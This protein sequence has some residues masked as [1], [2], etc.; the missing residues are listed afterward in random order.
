MKKIFIFLIAF[1]TSGVT[2]AADTNEVCK[3][4]TLVMVVLQ[5]KTNGKSVDYDKDTMRWTVDFGYDLFASAHPD[6]VV[7]TDIVGRTTCNDINV[8]SS[9]D[10]KSSNAGPAEPGDANTFLKASHGDVG[11]NCWCKMDGPVTSWWTYVKEYTSDSECA[12]YCTEYCAT[13]FSGNGAMSNNLPLREA[14]FNKIW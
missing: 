10:G 2:Y 1:L 5:N 9:D 14:L 11:K 4:N 12:D 6:Y 3:R 8:K 7:R 13:N